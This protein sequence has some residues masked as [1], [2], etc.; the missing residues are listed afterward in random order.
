LPFSH[1]GI[2]G[3]IV[4][5][6]KRSRKEPK[7]RARKRFD[8]SIICWALETFALEVANQSWRISAIRSTSGWLVRTMRSSYQR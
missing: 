7:Q 8:W 3:S 6:L 5:A 2:A 4:A 1:C